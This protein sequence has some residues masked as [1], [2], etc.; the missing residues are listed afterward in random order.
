MWKWSDNHPLNLKCMKTPGHTNTNSINTNE[1]S[2]DEGI[3]WRQRQ[4]WEPTL[5]VVSEPPEPQVLL[6][7]WNTARQ[8][9]F[10]EERRLN[11]ETR[12]NQIRL[13]SS[14]LLVDEC[15][16]LDLLLR[17]PNPCLEIVTCQV[18]VQ[19]L[20]TW[21]KS[22]TPVSAHESNGAETSRSAKSRSHTQAR[23]WEWFGE[24]NGDTDTFFSGSGVDQNKRSYTS[25]ALINKTRQSSNSR[26]QRGAWQDE[27]GAAAAWWGVKEAAAAG[28]NEHQSGADVW[29]RGGATAR[30]HV[31]WK[32]R[33]RAKHG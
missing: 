10:V 25:V 31:V 3:E 13:S 22:S 30:Q 6:V 29:A 27:E 28:S 20:D 19:S 21:G 12:P 15:Q 7:V 2:G 4:R 1:F 9:L 8:K 23:W 5:T 24:P 32:E 33:G 16:R 18:M 17:N 26:G 14:E 11:T